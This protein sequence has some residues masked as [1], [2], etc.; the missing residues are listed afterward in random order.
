MSINTGIIDQRVRKLAEDL[1]AEFETRLNIKNDEDKQRSVSFVFL[2]VKTIL[3]LP[4]EQALDCLTEGG[5]DFGVDALHIGDVEDGEFVVTLFQ[6]KYKRDLA[7]DANFP[8]TGVE[9]VIQAIK[10]GASGKIIDV[11][12]AED[13]EHVEIYVE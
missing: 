11:E 1:A 8:Q 13:G 4:D 6:G 3:D 9:K 2:V 10:E 12:D 7:G 5:N